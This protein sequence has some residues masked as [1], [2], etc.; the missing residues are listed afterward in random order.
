MSGTLD[1]LTTIPLQVGGRAGRTHNGFDTAARWLLVGIGF[2]IPVS[3]SISEILTTLFV[4]CCL[5]RGGAAQRL[6]QIACNP[7]A[8]G[9]AAMFL[10]LA[11][12]TIYSSAT[13]S[14]A[15]RCL[16][17]Y[18]EFLYLP[19]MVTVFAGDQPLRRLGM[20]A[21]YAGALGVLLLS[22]AEWLTGADIG[23]ESAKFDYVIF[24]DRIIHSL[25]MALLVYFSV[26]EATRASKP[27]R[28]F[29]AA[30]IALAALNIVFLVQ[31]RTGYLLIGVLTILV[32]G[33]RFG[34]RGVA[35]ACLLVPCAAAV[36]YA[37]SGVVQYRF[38]Q[39]VRQ[40]RAEF[41][42]PRQ[43]Q[44]DPRLEYYMVTLR[45]IGGSPLC[46]TGTGSFTS[47]YARI[48]AERSA[49]AA[50]GPPIEPTTDPHNEY[51]HLATQLGIPGAVAY[52]LLLAL[53]WVLANRLPPWDRNLAR[54]TAL[55]VG[56]G[57]L[58]NSLILSVTGGL[59]FAY[60]GA[61]SL[62]EL[63]RARGDADGRL[64]DDSCSGTRLPGIPG[65][66][67]RAA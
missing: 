27:M 53:Q 32:M 57:S 14:E 24:K 10:W 67:R 22:Y 36:A 12:A 35:I 64:A 44:W 54:G 5:L 16:L 13:W 31:G 20:R 43:S 61:L 11:L 6:R 4:V 3:T 55:A 41:G 15:G 33:Q 65:V 19:L 50:N 62:A 2:S 39:T 17:K 56:V 59:V 23:L 60:F 63:G 58:F 42:E 66:T 51:L 25:L 9:S 21:F 48:A 29:Y 45:L 26:Q 37:T 1:N 7:V 38:H 18:R 34:R 30:V 28:W 52:L 47:E 46:G 40:I 8:V 49:A